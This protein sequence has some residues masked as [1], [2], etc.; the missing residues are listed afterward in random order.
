MPIEL[1]AD[2]NT[3]NFEQRAKASAN[4]GDGKFNAVSATHGCYAYFYSCHGN[5]AGFGCGKCERNVANSVV[6]WEQGPGVGGF[7]CK[8]CTC[9]CQC[10]F[11]E[12]N[13]QNI[14]I[15]IGRKKKRL[16][17]QGNFKSGSNP[18]LA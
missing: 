8:A 9:G 18:S 16:D 4:G 13:W 12:H 6:A 1:Q 2:M 3:K 17:E 7:D 10:V 11:Q 5:V 15:G 14:C